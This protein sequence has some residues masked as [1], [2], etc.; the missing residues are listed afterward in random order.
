MSPIRCL[1]VVVHSVDERGR[2]EG[3]VTDCTEPAFRD[4]IP[5]K[6]H[7]P[8]EG[9]FLLPGVEELKPGSRYVPWPLKCPSTPI[10]SA[11]WASRI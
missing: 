6:L 2:D 8:I 9:P 1:L 5:E 11:M 10:S 3:F 7:E 4:L